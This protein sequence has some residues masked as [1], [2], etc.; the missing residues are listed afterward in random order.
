MKFGLLSC[1]VCLQ[2]VAGRLEVWCWICI[3]GVVRRLDDVL[4]VKC[5]LVDWK[6]WILKMSLGSCSKFESLLFENVCGECLGVFLFERWNILCL[7]MSLEHFRTLYSLNSQNVVEEPSFL[8]LNVFVFDN[9]FE[10]LWML[11]SWKF[12]YFVIEHLFWEL[13]K[14]WKFDFWK[15]LEGV[16]VFLKVWNVD[17]KQ[18]FWKLLRVWVSERLNTLFLNTASERFRMF[19]S[20]LF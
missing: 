8:S 16:L 5:L 14:V 10:I 13:S 18:V 12:D 6:V 3:S 9:V 11:F 17:W 20:L 7:N 2:T 1:L 15:F 19:E 4:F